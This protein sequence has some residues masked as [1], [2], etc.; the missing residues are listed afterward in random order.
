MTGV[1]SW[2][3]TP[4]TCTLHKVLTNRIQVK[5]QVI[6]TDLKNQYFEIIYF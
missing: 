6:Q 4:S 2:I 1:D 5:V 3:G